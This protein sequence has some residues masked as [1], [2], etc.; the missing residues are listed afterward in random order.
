M[1]FTDFFIRRA[2]TTTLIM[3]GILL[4]GILSYTNLPVSELPQVEYPTI[5]VSASLPGANPF[6]RKN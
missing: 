4:F 1:N 3:V 5:Q 6:R 2:V